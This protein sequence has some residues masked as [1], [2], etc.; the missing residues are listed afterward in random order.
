MIDPLVPRYTALQKENVVPVHVEGAKLESKQVAKHPKVLTNGA[1]W[2]ILTSLQH[3]V[4]NSGL[5]CKGLQQ[6][7]D[8]C[9]FRIELIG[10]HSP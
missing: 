9:G 2:L 1:M 7:A 10:F 3:C 6:P 8:G 5:K 4:Y